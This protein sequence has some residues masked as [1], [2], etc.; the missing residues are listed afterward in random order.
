MNGWRLAPPPRRG[1]WTEAEHAYRQSLLTGGPSAETCF[2][3][4]N[5]LYSLGQYARSGERYRQVVELDPDFWEAWNNLGTVLSYEGDN[6]AAVAAYDR[7]LA[8]NPRYADAHY[9]LADTLEDLDRLAEAREHW[10]TYLEL[11]PRGAWAEHAR[12]RLRESG[13]V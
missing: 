7:A 11:E 6:E 13:G 2:N 12:E 4:A 3:L 9:N 1:S 5:V 10:L 8:L